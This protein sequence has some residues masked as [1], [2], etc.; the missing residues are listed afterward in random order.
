[1]V[2]NLLKFLLVFAI[3]DE[4]DGIYLQLVNEM[5]RQFNFTC[6]YLVYKAWGIALDN[7]TWIGDG[8]SQVIQ[9]GKIDIVANNMWQVPEFYNQ[10][11]FGPALN[12]VWKN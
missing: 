9:E 3:P 4:Y 12:K 10:V 2:L 11:D 6:R 7:G 1:M 8:L 5:A